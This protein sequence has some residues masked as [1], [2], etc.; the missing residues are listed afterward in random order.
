MRHHVI[1]KSN[2]L[3]NARENAVGRLLRLRSN[4]AAGENRA[5][6]FSTFGRE[7]EACLLKN[8]GV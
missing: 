7:R 5:K 4:P 1:P 2:G 8:A 6:G 3:I